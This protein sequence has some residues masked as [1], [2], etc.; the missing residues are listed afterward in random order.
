[1]HDGSVGY[2]SVLKLFVNSFLNISLTKRL[3]GHRGLMHDGSVSYSSV[4][5]AICSYCS[6]VSLCRQCGN[7]FALKGHLTTHMKR[8]VGYST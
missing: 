3:L 8:I 2:P 7:V 1:M 5:E 4:L 6:C